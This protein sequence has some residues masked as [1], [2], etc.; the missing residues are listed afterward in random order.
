M[1]TRG[2]YRPPN[3]P[4]DGE[5]PL[6]LHISAVAHLETTV[7]RIKAVERAAAMVEEILKNGSAGSASKPFS[8][9]VY[10]G[11]K[12]DPALNIAARIRGPNVS[13]VTSLYSM[14]EF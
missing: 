12:A 1:I 11:F 9:S 10:L 5:R 14:L 13:S 3:A 6:Y 2:K 7:D 8:T 4:N